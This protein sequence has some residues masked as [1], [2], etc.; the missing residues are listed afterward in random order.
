MMEF[1]KFSNVHILLFELKIRV[2]HLNNKI[3]IFGMIVNSF[4]FV[5]HIQH[6]HLIL[7]NV[8]YLP[9]LYILENLK[10]T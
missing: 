2:F 9:T 8:M 10:C 5:S 6:L 7:F 4:V 1:V 3:I